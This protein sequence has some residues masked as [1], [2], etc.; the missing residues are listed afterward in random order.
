M[1]KILC[2]E[3]LNKS[4]DPIYIISVYYSKFH[5]RLRIYT[6]SVLRPI[7]LITSQ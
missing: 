5:E 1:A 4:F 6:S 7:Y 2:Y 3:E